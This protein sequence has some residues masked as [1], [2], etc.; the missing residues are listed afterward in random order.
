[1]TKSSVRAAVDIGEDRIERRLDAE[2]SH[3]GE[4]QR[5]VE[6]EDDVADLEQRAPLA[7]E[8]G[9]DLGPVEDR[10]AAHGQ[11]D[12]GADEEPAEDGGQQQVRRH[13]REVDRGQHHREA[14][15]R[16][17]APH[18]ERAAHV[19]V[20]DNDER[21]VDDRQPDRE[22]PR[23]QLRQQH[24]HAGDAAVDE[25]AR[26]QEPLQPHRGGEDAEEN[27]QDIES[28][29]RHRP[30][31]VTESRGARR[32]APCA[33]RSAKARSRGRAAARVIIT[34]SVRRRADARSCRQ[35]T[36]PP[37][38][39]ARHPADRTAAPGRPI[40]RRSRSATPPV[41]RRQALERR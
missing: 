6:E 29:A 31:E 10:A 25:V 32:S 16:E 30:H 35:S 1:M 27:Q 13:V 22:R 14:A 3:R 20:A 37:R 15:N 38:G 36:A 9:R 26:Q 41:P 2:Q 24:R 23:R 5:D 4:E 17:R 11:A 7:D 39:G 28:F 8:E 18:G 40:A 21:R 12:A 33:S 34:P 19:L